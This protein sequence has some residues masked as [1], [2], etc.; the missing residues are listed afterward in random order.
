MS[1]LQEAVPF[2][3][4][5]K[6]EAIIEFAVLQIEAERFVKMD[7]R[8]IFFP[9][10]QVDRFQVIFAAGEVDDVLHQ[11]LCQAATTEVRMHNDALYIADCL[12]VLGGWQHQFCFACWLAP[13]F[14]EKDEGMFVCRGVDGAKVFFHIPVDIARGR[15]AEAIKLLDQRD[16]LGGSKTNHQR[17]CW[18]LINHIVFFL[19]ETITTNRCG[20]AA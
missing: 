11:A 4:S 6:A 14:G 3:V 7:G 2:H 1:T 8:V 18:L 16:I 19:K 13:Y 20:V 15:C 10:V 9:D 5:V 17:L 12:S